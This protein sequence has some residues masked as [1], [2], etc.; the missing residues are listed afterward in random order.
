MSILAE[1]GAIIPAIFSGDSFE[2]QQAF[3]TD[4]MWVI[5]F[6]VT[7]IG[8]FLA[9]EFFKL[10]PFPIQWSPY[11]NDSDSDSDSRGS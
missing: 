7:L 5:S 6:L 8:G 3:Y 11:Y 10:I 2:M 9:N 1:A 4:G